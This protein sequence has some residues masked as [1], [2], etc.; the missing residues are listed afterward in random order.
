MFIDMLFYATNCC[1]TTPFVGFNF[2]VLIVHFTRFSPSHHCHAIFLFLI[3]AK[4]Y[5]DDEQLDMCDDTCGSDMDDH[6]S[7]TDSKKSDSRTPGS[8]DGKQSNNSKPRRWVWNFETLKLSD[9]RFIIENCSFQSTDCIHVRTTSVL[10]E[11]VQNDK[12]S[13][14]VWTSQPGAQ[15]ESNWNTSKFFKL[16]SYNRERSFLIPHFVSRWKSGFKIVGPS[17]K[18]KIP[19][20]TSTA[21]PFRRRTIISVPE[22]T[23]VAFY[24]P[25]PCHIHRTVRT[26]TIW[27]AI[28]WAIHTHRGGTTSQTS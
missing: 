15:P 26:F 24:I 1:L 21:P 3:P 25:T 11:Q 17:G 9:N 13:V 8:G 7:D 27:A 23:Q 14:G 4:D 6:M 2:H 19:E 5:N 20:W 28:T 16:Y 22:R 12:V 18:S 10:R